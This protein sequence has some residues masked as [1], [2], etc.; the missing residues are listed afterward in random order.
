MIRYKSMKSLKK[1]SLILGLSLLS[2]CT[3]MPSYAQSS[4]QQGIAAIVNNDIITT[5][6]LKQRVLYMLVTTGAQ[7]DEATLARI[8]RQA[9][10]L[11]RVAC[12][13]RVVREIEYTWS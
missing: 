6:D 2:L 3:A 13:F 1:N 7:R 8:Q 5:Y 10:N 12:E 11:T 9:M 4:T